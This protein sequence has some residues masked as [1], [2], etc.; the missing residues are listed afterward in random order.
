MRSH[1]RTAVTVD[2]ELIAVDAFLDERLVDQ[3]FG[4][5]LGLPVGEHPAHDAPAVDVEDDVEV[6]VGPLGR[7]Q[8]LRDVPCPDLIGS[9]SRQ[10]WLGIRGMPEPVAALAD[11]LIGLEDAMHRVDGAEIGAPVQQCCVGFSWSLVGERLVMEDSQHP[12]PFLPVQGPRRC[13]PR[14]PWAVGGG[15]PL[16]SFGTPMAEHATAIPTEGVSS[17][18]AFM[19]LSRSRLAAARSPGS[20][21]V[22][23]DVQN[24]LGPPWPPHELCVLPDQPRVLGREGRVRVGLPPTPL[25]YEAGKRRLVALLSPHGKMRRAETFPP[26]QSSTLPG[27]GELIRLPENAGLVS[28]V[29]PS[30]H[31]LSGT[32]SS[33][34]NILWF[35]IS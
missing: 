2:R 20:R 23:L 4:K 34:P 28:G 21:R 22:F 17:S 27:P 16:L 7:P 9:S 26:Q 1:G 29:E 8:Q 14:Q 5:V 3:S 35:S 11:L 31:G 12:L 15:R 19:A 18:T 33:V 25:G 32:A 13:L 30:L 24:R 10:L 6:V